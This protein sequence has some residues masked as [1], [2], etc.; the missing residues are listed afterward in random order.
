MPEM[1]TQTTGW[2]P[3]NQANRE[4]IIEALTDAGLQIVPAERAYAQAS[5]ADADCD[6]PRGANGQLDGLRTKGIASSFEARSGA[7]TPVNDQDR[8]GRR[9]AP[10][11]R[12]RARSK[13]RKHL[14]GVLGGHGKT[15]LTFGCIRM[16]NAHG[17]SRWL[18]GLA[19]SF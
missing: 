7:Q 13:D 15:H 18:L 19:A 17:R 6:L 11:G 5:N 14:Q 3:R 9:R 16:M 8:S 10:S 2:I 12:R 4:S 1:I